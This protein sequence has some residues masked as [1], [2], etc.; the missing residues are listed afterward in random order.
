MTVAADARSKDLL[1][2]S[3]AENC[4]RVGRNTQVKLSLDICNE[5][6]PAQTRQDAV[7]EY[8]KDGYDHVFPAQVCMAPTLILPL[9]TGLEPQ[10]IAVLCC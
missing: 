2:Q 1:V 9:L 5:A 6:C 4:T 7:Q 10:E 8:L 3:Q